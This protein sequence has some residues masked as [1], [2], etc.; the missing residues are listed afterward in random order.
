M[1]ANKL[2]LHSRL[3]RMELICHSPLTLEM[4]VAVFICHSP[5]TL[6]IVLPSLHGAY[7]SL[8]PHAGNSKASHTKND[9]GIGHQH[10]L[11]PLPSIYMNLMASMTSAFATM[12][13][14]VPYSPQAKNRVDFRNGGRGASMANNGPHGKG[15]AGPQGKG[16]SKTAGE[17]LGA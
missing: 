2:A 9:E 13:A 10:D 15:V 11:L 4:L 7:P 6:K 17:A 16:A 3:L 12:C 1:A 14:G 5:L 8:P